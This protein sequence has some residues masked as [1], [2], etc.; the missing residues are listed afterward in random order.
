MNAAAYKAQ[1]YFD[2]REALLRYL[3]DSVLAGHPDA[4][5]ADSEGM[6]QVALDGPAASQASDCCCRHA[7]ST[8]CRR[9]RRTCCWSMREVHWLAGDAVDVDLA[10]LPSLRT[11]GAQ[12]QPGGRGP[13]VL[14][15][16]G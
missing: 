5:T 11:A 6:R 3:G 16:P 14:A 13:G 10:R 7:P 12:R 15:A 1:I 4:P 8:R 9:C 2:Q